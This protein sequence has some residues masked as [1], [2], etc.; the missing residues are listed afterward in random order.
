MA[1][2]EG[3]K[4]PYRATFDIQEFSRLRQGLTPK[5]MD[6]KWFV[7]YQQP[8]LFLNRS[9][10]GMPAY[11]ITLKEKENSVKVIEALW[12]RK[13]AEESKWGLEY[14]AQLLDFLISNLLLGQGKPFPVAAGV[15]ESSSP[16]LQHNISGTAYPESRTRTRKRWWQLW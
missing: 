13:L 11:R 15:P 14:E 3:V 16:A 8:Y 2:R 6:D 10:T 1:F 5:S 4:I 7:Y 9:W 12:S